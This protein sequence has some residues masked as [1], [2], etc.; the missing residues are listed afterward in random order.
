MYYS[1]F[2][3]LWAIFLALE[4]FAGKDEKLA[5]ENLNNST[6]PNTY[7]HVNKERLLGLGEAALEELLHES[8]GKSRSAFDED[9]ELDFDSF[10]ESTTIFSKLIILSTYYL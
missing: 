1:I 5:L 4:P 8:R 9:E 7:L 2:A 10:R 3:L 6:N